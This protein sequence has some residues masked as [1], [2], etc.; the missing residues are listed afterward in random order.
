M[1]WM[2]LGPHHNPSSLLLAPTPLHPLIIG[3]TGTGRC[4]CRR[5]GLQVNQ[6]ISSATKFKLLKRYSMV[7]I[8]IRR[9]DPILNL[10]S[11]IK[12]FISMTPI[13]CNQS[14]IH[15]RFLEYK[16]Y[17]FDSQTVFQEFAAFP[18]LLMKKQG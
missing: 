3:I 1:L 11:L 10:K 5:S 9:L 14:A 6:G 17:L 18:C 12:I 4:Q 7:S 8:K 2:L 13:W 16:R 15:L